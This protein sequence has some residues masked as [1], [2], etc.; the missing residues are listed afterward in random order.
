MYSFNNSKQR[1]KALSCIQRPISIIKRITSKHH[2]DF[3]CLNSFHSFATENKL[4][5]HKRLSENNNFYNIIIPSEEPK[6]LEFN[7]Y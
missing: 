2:R 6:I 5:S 7:Q 3:C 1:R 4:Q